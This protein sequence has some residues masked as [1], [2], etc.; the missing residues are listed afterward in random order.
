MSQST[1][2][3]THLAGNPRL[4]DGTYY[5]I[6]PSG[7]EDRDRLARC[8]EVLSPSSRRLR[9]FG[10]KPTLQAHELDLYTRV[11]GRDHIAFAAV[12][13]DPS[14]QEG[15]TLGFAR[16]MRLA[17]E[18]E[19]AELS[20]TVVDEAQGQG[21]GGALLTHL[22][23]AALDQGILRFRCEVLAENSGMRRL[24][25]A[26]GGKALWL[27]DG[28]L[29]YDCPLPAPISAQLDPGYPWF[30]D[31]D[32][33]VQVCTEVWLT[34]LADTLAR[35]EA[36]DLDWNQWLQAACPLPGQPGAIL[37]NPPGALH[38]PGWSQPQPV[39]A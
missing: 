28:T 19:T 16:C 25:D 34:N 11:D 7:P 35:I 23:A 14:G 27:G 29:E 31:A 39:A 9:F 36:A 30:A 32:V 1:H 4:K 37:G 22:I 33:W 18:S 12:Q 24:A 10:V 13:L 5:R 3:T 20:L 6:R 38:S 2:A 17:P 8:F 21:V 26:L 15:Q